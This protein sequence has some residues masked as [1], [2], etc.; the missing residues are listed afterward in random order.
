M[1]RRLGQHFLRAPSVER[2]LRV[3][4]PRADDV[5]LEIGPGAG[6]LTLPRAGRAAGVVAVEIDR[7]LADRL[8]GSAPANVEIVTADA[9]DADLKALVPIGGRLVGNLPY[10]VSSPLL[11]R[12][13]DLRER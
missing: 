7:P 1:P 5:F 3:I 13:L 10:Y 11:R 4:A 12:F 6:A 2:L 9:L 8:R